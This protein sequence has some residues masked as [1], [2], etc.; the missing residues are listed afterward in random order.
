MKGAA[1]CQA[2]HLSAS[3][4]AAALSPCPVSLQLRSSCS[5]E[6]NLLRGTPNTVFEMA[7]RFTRHTVAS[8]PIVSWRS[9][10]L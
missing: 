2:A 4:Q 3:L 5:K 7:D 6:L 8:K 10:Q 9:V 1:T